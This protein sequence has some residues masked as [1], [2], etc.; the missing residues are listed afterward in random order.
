[1]TLTLVVF[2]LMVFDGSGGFELRTEI[3]GE[4]TCK[5]R[6]VREQFEANPMHVAQCLKEGQALMLEAKRAGA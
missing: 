3:M 1:M 4:Q 5:L 6:L 2:V